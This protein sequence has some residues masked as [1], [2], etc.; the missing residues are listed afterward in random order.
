MNRREAGEPGARVVDKRKPWEARVEM[1]IFKLPKNELSAY[2]KLVYAVLCGHANRDG[3]AMLYVRTIAGEAS[4]SERQAR[5]A[6][7]NLEACRLLIRRAQSKAG[8]GQIFNIYEVYGFD[9]YTPAD[10]QPPPLCQTGISPMTISHTP[11]DCQAGPN[12]VLEQ[13]L[14]NRL[15][16]NYTPPA[17][18]G[19]AGG[20]ESFEPAIPNPEPKTLK[21]GEPKSDTD[22]APRQLLPDRC[23]YQ[24]I[25]DTYDSALPELPKAG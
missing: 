15:K 21:A 2:D 16:K 6:L 7:S 17:P 9:G 23:D 10:S 8:Q 24:A 4:C 14:K 18:L 19:G 1:N 3:D 11:P 5:R 12:N 20:E 13:P 22:D 25:A